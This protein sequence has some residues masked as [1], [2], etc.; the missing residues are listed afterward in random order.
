TKSFLMPGWK[1]VRL[2]SANLWLEH[3][4]A[5]VSLQKLTAENAENAEF[6][7]DESLRTLCYYFARHS[8]ISPTLEPDA[9]Y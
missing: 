6:F 4:L 1:L 5:H 8:E 3:S 2:S 9:S 7:S